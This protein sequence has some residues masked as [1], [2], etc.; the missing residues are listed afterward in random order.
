MTTPTKAPRQPAPAAT[1]NTRKFTVEEYYRMAEVGIL[2]DTERVELIN[3]EIVLMPPI[4]INHAGIVNRWTRFLVEQARGR[5]SVQIQNPVRIGEHS[6]PQPDVSI[7]LFRD[8]DYLNVRPGP[9]ETLVAV[10]VSDTSLAY[11]R[12]TKVTI[13]SQ[14]GIP[15][16]WVVNLPEDCI[17]VFTEASVNGYAQHTVYRRGELISPSTLADVEFAVADLLPPPPASNVDETEGETQAEA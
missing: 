8:D 16:T 17:E 9:E 6:E 11:D 13:Y 12:G 10:E 7:L 5:Y 2:H 15:E 1:L 4:G 14:A 3:G